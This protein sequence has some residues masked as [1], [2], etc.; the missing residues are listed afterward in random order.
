MAEPIVTMA[1]LFG[2]L[3]PEQN[4][5][6]G[7]TIT[8]VLN[9]SRERVWDAWTKPEKFAIWFGGRDL[10]MVNVNM[11]VRVGGT[12]SGTMMGPSQSIISWFGHY[13]EVEHPHRL[14]FDFTDGGIHGQIFEVFTV[15]FAN[16]GHGRTQMVVRQSGGHLT[17]EQ[18]ESTKDLLTE[19]F[20]DVLAEMLAAA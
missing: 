2:M 4:A 20:L 12:W 16:I 15:T 10:P 1:E 3:T 6:R 11:D 8:R 5:R 13:L 19:G 18:Y 9:F 17:D 14:V 7:Y